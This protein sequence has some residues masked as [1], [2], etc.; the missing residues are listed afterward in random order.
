[1]RLLAAAQPHFNKI[2][3]RVYLL[4]FYTFLGMSCSLMYFC[5]QNHFLHHQPNLVKN[6]NNEI[7]NIPGDNFGTVVGENP[8]PY[9][10][11]ALGVVNGLSRMGHTMGDICPFLRMAF[12]YK[13]VNDE[14]I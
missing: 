6:M 5:N 14:R 9:V 3:G 7:I 2:F 12:R 4:H 11:L 10:I 1:M 8:T 13:R